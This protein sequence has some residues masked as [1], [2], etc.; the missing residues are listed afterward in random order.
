MRALLSAMNVVGDRM[1]ATPPQIAMS[2]SPASAQYIQDTSEVSR[3]LDMLLCNRSSL[4]VNAFLS[5]VIRTGV[6]SE[7]SINFEFGACAFELYLSGTRTFQ[8]PIMHIK[9]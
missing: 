3:N 9:F 6:L 5:C 2:L 4:H 1:H 8:L 7:I